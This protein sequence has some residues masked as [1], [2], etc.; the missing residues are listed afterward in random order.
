MEPVS[1]AGEQAYLGTGRMLA[2]TVDALQ[3][4]DQI[5]FLQRILSWVEGELGD[6]VS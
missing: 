6:K 1:H 3:Q 2:A 4:D 5:G